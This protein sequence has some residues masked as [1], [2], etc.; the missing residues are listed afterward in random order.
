MYYIIIVKMQLY[1]INKRE[2]KDITGTI[3]AE[4]VL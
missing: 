3:N 4:A 1:N 2:N